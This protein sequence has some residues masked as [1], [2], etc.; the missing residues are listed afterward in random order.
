M[1]FNPA[2]NG[3]KPAALPATDR[4]E[5][6]TVSQAANVLATTSISSP[7]FAEELRALRTTVAIDIPRD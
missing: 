5:A 2:F 3:H 6:W 4:V 1:A 7:R